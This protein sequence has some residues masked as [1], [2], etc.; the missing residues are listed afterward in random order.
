MAAL[1]AG[2]TLALDDAWT[3]LDGKPAPPPLRFTDREGRELSLNNFLGRPVALNL[4][5]T[6]CSPCVVELPALDRLQASLGRRGPQVLAL[7][8]DR[9]GHL[10]VAT[11]FQRLKIRRLRSLVDASGA[12][13]D[14]LKVTGL[15]TTFLIRADG[16]LIARRS[17]AIAWDEASERTHLLR[18]L[19]L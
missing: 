19:G 5:A 16:A 7:S 13:S 12:A 15:P 10:A 18:R 3:L 11:A 17:G 14:Q 6:W 8:L 1:L 9:R 4:W 2:P